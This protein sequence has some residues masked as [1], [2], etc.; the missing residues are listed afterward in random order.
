[1][2]RT[3]GGKE[4][5]ILEVDYMT[6]WGKAVPTSRITAKEVANFVFNSIFLQVWYSL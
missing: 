6:R 5:I 1:M 4:Y 2:P 3:V